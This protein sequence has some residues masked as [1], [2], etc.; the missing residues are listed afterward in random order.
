[1]NFLNPLVLFGMVAAGIPILLHLLNLRRLKTV[2]FSTVRF[3]QELQQTRVRRLRIQQI[4]L[5]VLRTLIILFAVLAFARPTIPGNLPLLSIEARSSV[6]ILVDNSTSMEAADQR[7]ERFRQARRAAEQV[8]SLLRDG[9]EVAVIPMAGRD[10]QRNV[11]FTRSFTAARQELERITLSDDRADLPAGFR[12]ADL[13]FTD[14]AHPYR[15]VYV[16]SD[17]Q[18][19]IVTRT[20]SDTSRA[21]TTSA[22]V[23]LVRIGDGVK[24]L[25]PNLSVDSVAVRTTLVQPDRPVEL[26]AF[27][28][29]GSTQDASNVLVTLAFDGTRVAQQ[30]IDVAAGTTRSVVVAA[31]PQRRG[32]V[33]ASVELENDAIDRDNV[34]YAGITIPERSRVAIIGEGTGARLAQMALSVLGLQGSLPQTTVLD[35]VR[36]LGAAMRAYD[37]AVLVD[38][39][40]GS[41]DASVL[42]QYVQQGGGLVVFASDDDGASSVLRPYGLDVAAVQTTTA[43]KPWTITGVVRTHPLFAGVFKETTDDRGVAESPRLTRLRPA[44]GGTDLMRTPAGALVSEGTSP[45]GRVIYVAASPRSDWGGLG[46]TGI[47]PMLLVRGTLYASMPRDAGMHAA[48]GERVQAPV[49][50]RM[51][52]TATFALTDVNGVTMTAASLPQYTGDVVLVP[53]QAKAGVVKVRTQDSAAVLAVTIHRP[54]QESVLSFLS[55]AEWRTR[56]LPTVAAADR[57]VSVDAAD[58]MDRAVRHARVGSELWPLF[59][60]LALCCALA[61]MVVARM[62]MREAADASMT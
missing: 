35:G 38:A 21:L 4:L 39:T 6:V 24:G 55:D 26:E 59:I 17:A 29:N 32:I 57:I 19:D 56:V 18:R 53:A 15:D 1:M 44:R 23:F 33:A 13:L 58:G 42:E 48:I 37:V 62:G 46:A 51:A 28:R 9:D 25:E 8:L 60:V 11:A 47:F 31:P 36:A 49:P 3:L 61:E 10:A 2:D 40:I 30:A 54:A 34:R 14:A 27:V 45:N 50:P 52:G 7:G 43:D 5:L 16:V 22:N 20:E 12:A 41:A